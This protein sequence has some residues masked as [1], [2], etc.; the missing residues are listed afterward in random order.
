MTV[1]PGH[2]AQF[3]GCTTHHLRRL[4]REGKI[5]SVGNGCARRY[6]LAS[7]QTYAAQKKTDISSEKDGHCGHRG[8]FDFGMSVSA[9]NLESEVEHMNLLSTVSPLNPPAKAARLLGLTPKHLT[10]MIDAGA[11][12]VVAIGDERLIPAYW[13]RQ[14]L[15]KAYDA[16]ATPAGQKA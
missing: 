15:S 14:M 11:V 1:S 8:H 2:A 3:L 6:L 13:L 4:A 12:P 7:L 9:G 5:A 16:T 10:G